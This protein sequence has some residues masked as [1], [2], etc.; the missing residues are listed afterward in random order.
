MP[1]TRFDYV[2]L[3]TFYNAL[4]IT[5]VNDWCNIMAKPLSEHL[6]GVVKSMK[7]ESTT[8]HWQDALAAIGDLD[9]E[10][11]KEAE[12]VGA[13]RLAKWAVKTVLPNQ[14]SALFEDWNDGSIPDSEGGRVARGSA[15]VAVYDWQIAQMN[16]AIASFTRAR[17]QL[18]RDRAALLQSLDKDSDTH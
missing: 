13:E 8:I 18:I 14:Q 3:T 17:D 2:L 1:C 6:V 7:A 12:T 16:K 9:A 11:R 5:Y 15:D 4:N 10:E